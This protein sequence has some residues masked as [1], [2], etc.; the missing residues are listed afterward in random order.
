MVIELSPYMVSF[1]RANDPHR[2]LHLWPGSQVGHIP[3]FT[4]STAIAT[5]LRRLLGKQ[6]CRIHI[7]VPA[8]LLQYHQCMFAVGQQE[9]EKRSG[10]IK[11]I[12]Q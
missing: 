8:F 4:L 10:C 5:K 6:R 1:S 3:P 2:G 12:G 9:V 7:Q 11:R